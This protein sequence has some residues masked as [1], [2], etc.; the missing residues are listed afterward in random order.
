MAL[1]LPS[2]RFQLQKL[3]GKDP[4]Q[5]L[6]SDFRS[7][8]LTRPRSLPPKYFYDETGSKLFNEICDT[9]EYYP[10]RTEY[11]LLKKHSSR[12]MNTVQPHTCVELGAGVSLKTELLLSQ[13]NFDS[14]ARLYVTIDVCGEMLVEA[15]ER[16]LRKFSL[17]KIN[18]Y[19]GEYIPCIRS[20]PKF[21]APVLYI[22]LGSSIGNFSENEAI[23]LLSETSKRMNSNDYF[24]LGI[25][26]VKDSDILEKAYNDTKG[27]TA[28]F[29]INVL[30]VLNSKLEANF[31]LENF[32]H[33][34]IYNKPK[35]QIEMYLISK[36]SQNVSFKK[37]NKSIK[38]DENEKILTEVSRKYTRSSIQN[39]LT[40]SNLVET[41]HFEPDN[42]YFS[43]VLAKRA[44]YMK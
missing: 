28:E 5:T 7:E 3:A 26:R 40:K 44:S 19:I 35:E 8:M 4:L 38:F 31:L 42:Q 21:E 27:V 1:D 16:L 12:I 11:G 17:L 36:V 2:D 14:Y 10:T 37:L 23:T 6:M 30:N 34:A 41:L 22:F 15:A 39:L 13:L 29:N 33:Q 20:T 24:L 43:L 25:D 9:S 32:T 18:S